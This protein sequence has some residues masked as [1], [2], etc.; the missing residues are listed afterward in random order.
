MC[1]LLFAPKKEREKSSDINL[2]NSSVAL[3]YYANQ[4]TDFCMRAT[5]AFNELKWI[6]E[7]KTCFVL[8]KDICIAKKIQFI[9]N[10]GFPN[11]ICLR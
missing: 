3:T 7:R 1:Y 8:N 9:A 5:L 6:L 10:C 11:S 2:L 4:L